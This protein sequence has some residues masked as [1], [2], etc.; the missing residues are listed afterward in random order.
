MPTLNKPGRLL[1][2]L[3]LLIVLALGLAL[4]F[5]GLGQRIDT[6]MFALLPRDQR[7]PM[8]ETALQSLAQHGERHLVFMLGSTDPDRAAAAARAF[9]QDIAP[10]PLT[11]QPLGETLSA[12]S[13][14]YAPYRRNLLSPA[15][16][17]ALQEKGT[18]WTQRALAAAYS[19][20]A[21][22]TLAFKDDPF[23]FFG[24]W[25]QSLAGANKVRPLDGLLRASSQGMN[26]VVL[27]Y[28]LNGSAFSLGLQEQVLTGLEAAAQKLKAQYPDVQL[29]RAGVVL[30]AATAAR[31]ARSEMSTIGVGST[32]GVILLAL[33]VFRGVRPLLLA[34]L[35]VLVG[36]LVSTALT[37]AW[38][39]H[40]HMLTLVFGTSLVGVAVDYSLLALA[41]GIDSAEPVAARYRKLLPSMLLAVTTMSLGYLGLALTPFP[42]LAQ[43]AVF[44]VVGIIGAWLTV[45]LWFPVLEQHGLHSTAM[46]RAIAGLLA[47]WPRIGGRRWA[48]LLPLALLVGAGLTQLKQNDDIRALSGIDPQLLAEQIDIGRVMGLPSP[49]QLFIVSGDTPEQVLERE[50]TLRDQLAPF[51][52]SGQLAGAEMLSRWVPSIAMQARNAGLVG[53]AITQRPGRLENLADQ[54][55]LPPDWVQEQRRV[56][57]PLQFADWINSPAALAANYLWLGQQNG[58]YASM[59]LLEGLGDKATT[60]RVGQIKSPGVVWVDKVSE[61]S[62]LMARY[63]QLL[64]RVLIGAYVLAFAVLS[65]RYGR[66]TWR[67]MLPPALATLA[68]LAIMGAVG[69]PLQ[70]LS[71]VTFLLVLGMGMD[72]GIFL[73]E[74]P[75]DGRVYLAVTLAAMCTLLSFGLLALSHTP[76]LH[77]F[78]FSTLCGIGLVWLLAPLFRKTAFQPAP[79]SGN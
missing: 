45:M 20:M 5:S 53:Q 10:L 66:Q 60:A 18:D 30:H 46:S 31:S 52:A 43:M 71:M 63:R 6:D 40:I 36:S 49:A 62:E 4:L 35:S 19:P 15:D 24:N 41:S 22:A 3:W 65:L 37:L 28:T 69:M 50:E 59:V 2:G 74:H 25:L 32:L 29:R 39:G 27:P 68:T 72:Y 13:N 48:W 8:A 61:I 76:A 42:G 1:A 38:F 12:I 34:A 47:R 11:A 57:P 79:E 33:L 78:G 77:A 44:A 9:A 16:A 67:I 75:D 17:T 51:M 58:G 56:T 55:G 26:Y 7:N 73:L 54:I 23:G 64:T 70:L 14:F 21:G